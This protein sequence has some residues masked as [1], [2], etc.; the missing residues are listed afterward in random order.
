MADLGRHLNAQLKR[1]QVPVKRGQKFLFGITLF[2]KDGKFGYRIIR[3][4]HSDPSLPQWKGTQVSVDMLIYETPAPRFKSAETALQSAED[5]LAKY[6][7]QT[8]NVTPED[9]TETESED[10]TEEETEEETP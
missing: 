7:E 3:K 6:R 2:E 5:W 10:A 9:A 1:L 4:A 8:L